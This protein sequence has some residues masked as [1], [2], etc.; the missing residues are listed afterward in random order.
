[1]VISNSERIGADLEALRTR[2]AL[3]IRQEIK[4]VHGSSRQDTPL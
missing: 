2:L 4:A 3:F 1:M